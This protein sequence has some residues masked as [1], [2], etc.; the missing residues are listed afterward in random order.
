MKMIL[1]MLTIFIVTGAVVRRI[2]PWVTIV[3]TLAVVAVLLFVR[4]TF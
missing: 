1:L 2:T 3:M 4:V